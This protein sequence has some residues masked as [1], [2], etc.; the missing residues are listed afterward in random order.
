MKIKSAILGA[1]GT[2]GQNF[3]AMLSA[4]PWFE[5]AGLFASKD[6]NFSGIPWLSP[7]E[8]P[9]NY[10]QLRVEKFNIE[11]IIN[12]EIRVVF[13][14]LPAGIA[15]EVE[16]ELQ[17]HGVAVFTN[18]SA[19]RMDLNVPIIIPEINADHISCIPAGTAPLIANSNCTTSGLVMTLAPLKDIGIKSVKVST[20]QSI[21]GAGYPGV[22]SLDITNNILPNIE[23][24]EIKIERETKKIMGMAGSGGIIPHEMDVFANTFRVG[25][26]HGHMESVFVEF[27]EEISTQDVLSRFV[28]WRG[29]TISRDLPSTPDSPLIVHQNP[30]RPQPK[31]DVMAGRG[32]SVGIGSIKVKRNVVS[33]KLLVNNVVRGAAG[34]SVQNAE[35]AYKAGLLK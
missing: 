25:V 17:K 6:R 4:H 23:G 5:L 19:H 35:L 20:Y 29:T 30:M 34:G 31:L 8:E 33:Y 26:T 9:S 21:S 28:E 27:D 15:S 13:S 24:E 7:F 3:I 2:V 32:M 14:A 22:A 16:L 1:S 10:S 12:S 18:A 11:S